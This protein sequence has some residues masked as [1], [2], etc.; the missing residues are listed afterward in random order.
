[1]NNNIE[2]VESPWGRNILDL[3]G[4][5]LTI[6]QKLW[7]GEFMTTNK[8][9]HKIIKNQFFLRRRVL[10]KYQHCFRNNIR[11]FS[12]GGRPRAIDEEGIENVCN[13]LITERPTKDHF[14]QILKDEHAQ[15]VCR[16]I[17]GLDP[18]DVKVLSQRSVGRYMTTL[19]VIEEFEPVD[20][21][22]ELC[23]R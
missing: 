8:N 1:M 5:R 11:M 3:R 20:D 10:Q 14:K 12:G 4:V 15:T 9:A 23:L 22:F 6:E 19:Y 18:D 17:L 16:R 2:L 21:N 13:F 7:L